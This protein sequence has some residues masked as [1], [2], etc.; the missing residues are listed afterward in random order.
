MFNSK[1]FWNTELLD[2]KNDLK[3]VK[4]H[5]MGEILN[6]LGIKQNEFK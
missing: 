2:D 1:P 6:S 3:P 5:K 4:D